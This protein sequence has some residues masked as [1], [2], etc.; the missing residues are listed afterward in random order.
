MNQRGQHLQQLSTLLKQAQNIP[1]HQSYRLQLSQWNHL[2]VR[3]VLLN[4]YE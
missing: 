2:I 3:Q 4:Y 1:L